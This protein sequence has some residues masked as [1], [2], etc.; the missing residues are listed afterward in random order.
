MLCSNSTEE[1]LDGLVGA[2][3]TPV[4]DGAVGAA[5]GTVFNKYQ[6]HKGYSGV[7]HYNA[8]SVD[9][10]DAVFK[11]RKV[12]AEYGVESLYHFSLTTMAATTTTTTNSIYQAPAAPRSRLASRR[13][14]ISLTFGDDE[15]R[16]LLARL[17]LPLPSPPVSHVPSSLPDSPLDLSLADLASSLPVTESY[18]ATST[19]D[20]THDDEE[21][22]TVEST[23]ADGE[24]FRG[25]GGSSAA[26]KMTSAAW[27]M[28]QARGSSIHHERGAVAGAGYS[29]A[30]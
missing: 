29:P 16:A 22:E 6:V 10:W 9:M 26:I 20:V 18:Y 23:G 15:H 3:V 7:D 30:V 27:P 14:A 5:A 2:T 4:L 12:A 1:F 8:E 13:G 19:N 21:E 25:T 28:N 17:S 24:Y 11:K